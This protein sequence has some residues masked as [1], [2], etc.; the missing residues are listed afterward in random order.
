MPAK[1]LAVASILPRGISDPSPNE[2]Q[3]DR[4][5]QGMADYPGLTV[6]TISRTLTQ[7]QADGLVALADRRR[8]R[9]PRPA[10][11]AELCE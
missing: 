11:L 9:L 1:T 7:L 4:R 5:R 3:A 6:E 10:A 2:D 8:V